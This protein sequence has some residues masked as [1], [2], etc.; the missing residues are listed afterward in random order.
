M[1]DDEF[2]SFVASELAGLAGVSAVALGGSRARGTEH[3]TSDWDY[4]VYYRRGFDPGVLRAKGFEGTVFEI[5]G[6]GG[7]VMNG[8]AWLTVEGR[9]VDVHYRDLGEVEHWCSEAQAGRFKKELLL[10]YAAGIPTYV[11]MAELATNIVLAGVLPRPAYPEALALEAARRWRA[12]AVAS[13]AYAQAA[14]HNRGDRLVSVAN[15]SRAL[16]EEAHCRLAERKVWVLNEKGMIE[17]A[18]LTDQADVL[19]GAS[20]SDELSE[21]LAA[22]TRSLFG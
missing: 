1:Q 18:G 20:N 16:I 13:L 5:G 8:G 9:R 11:V 19:C 22:I 6:W 17:T 10:F 2:N 21:A 12:D 3:D 7:G 15:A 4:A 14:L